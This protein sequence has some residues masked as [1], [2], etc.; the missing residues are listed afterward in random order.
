MSDQEKNQLKYE[1]FQW[2]NLFFRDHINSQKCNSAHDESIKQIVR[3]N[4]LKSAHSVCLP[5]SREASYCN[6]AYEKNLIYNLQHSLV[7]KLSH[8]YSICSITCSEIITLLTD[9]SRGIVEISKYLSLK[10]LLTT[11]QRILYK[12][13]SK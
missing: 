9:E 1:N 2:K 3:N 12:S 7:N 13:I 6:T 10:K 5:K 11:M 4:G 8:F